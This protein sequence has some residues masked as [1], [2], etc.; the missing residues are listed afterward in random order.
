MNRK[1]CWNTN[2]ILSSNTLREIFLKKFRKN[3]ILLTK[4]FNKENEK[5]IINHWWKS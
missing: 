4:N 3:L 1:F 2:H 5:T